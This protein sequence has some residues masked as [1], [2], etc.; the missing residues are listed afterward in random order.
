[1][2]EYVETVEDEPEGEL[3]LFPRRARKIRN[4]EK[5]REIYAYILEFNTATGS[6]PSVRNLCL[7]MGISSLSTMYGYIDRMQRAGWLYRTEGEHAWLCA[8]PGK[9][10]AQT[11]SQPQRRVL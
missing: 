10:E 3:V 5:W 2:T 7:A 8:C 6:G 1:M 4:E 11:A 9:L